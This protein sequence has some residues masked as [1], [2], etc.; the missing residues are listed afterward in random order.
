MTMTSRWVVMCT[1]VADKTNLRHEGYYYSEGEW[2]I[3]YRRLRV[4]ILPAKYILLAVMLYFYKILFFS[5]NCCIR[6]KI[7]VSYKNINSTLLFVN[8]KLKMGHHWIL[9]YCEQNGR[10]YTL[11]YF[12]I[13]FTVS[14]STAAVGNT[15][16]RHILSGV[17]SLQ[18]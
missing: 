4:S 11:R 14:V 2:R 18:M 17:I 7:P 6:V 13:F 9:Q 16:C 12:Y 1:E 5:G 15:R 10:P 8:D 3:F